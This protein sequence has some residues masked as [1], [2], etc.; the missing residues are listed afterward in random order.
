[1]PART[2]IATVGFDERHVLPALR[3]LPYDRL[4]AVGGRDA[5]RAPAFRRLL[6]IEPD[7]QR[8]P[9]DPFDLQ[10]CMEAI[11]RCVHVAQ[12]EGPVRISATGGTKILTMAAFLAAFQE[13]V[14]A[15][16]CDGPPLRLPVLRGARLADAF[17]A[18]EAAIIVHLRKA[19]SLES[20]LAAL[21]E[22]GFARR[23]VM[24]AILSLGRKGLVQSSKRT[25]RDV[26]RPSPELAS[27][28]SHFAGRPGKA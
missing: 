24:A 4:V 27:I 11:E 21:T 12:R 23:T 9:V 28:R 8:F 3:L 18:A 17:P 10:E 16:Y 7:L 25:G 20:L 19:M 13:G 2:L 1:M 22:L 15:W 14:E 6:S 26:V 5:F